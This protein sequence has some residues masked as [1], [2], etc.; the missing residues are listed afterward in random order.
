VWQQAIELVT[1]IYA[2]TRQLPKEELYGLTNQIRRSAVSVPSN[3]AEGHTRD[4]LK[5]YLQFL[6]ISLGSLAEVQTQLI[7]AKQLSYLPAQAFLDAENL[8]DKTFKM[9]KNLQRSLKEK[10]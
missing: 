6:S 2:I 9:I 10:L 1:M 5:E 8:A 3:I 4:H 7:I